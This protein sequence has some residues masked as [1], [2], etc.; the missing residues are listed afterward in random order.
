MKLYQ[1]LHHEHDVI[2]RLNPSKPPSAALSPF[3][4]GGR[5]EEKATKQGKRHSRSE[6]GRKSHD[7][8]WPI[9]SRGLFMLTNVNIRNATTY[10]KYYQAMAPFM[11]SRSRS[12]YQWGALH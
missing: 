7:L 10:T 5:V 2:R 11:R 4:V 6:L 3:R 12:R 1:L 9:Q 8:S